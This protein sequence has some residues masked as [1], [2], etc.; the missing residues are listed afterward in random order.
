MRGLLQPG[1]LLLLLPSASQRPSRMRSTCHCNRRQLSCPASCLS[2]LALCLKEVLDLKRS[3]AAWDRQGG[4]GGRQEQK[5]T[6]WGA[7][8]GWD[9]LHARHATLLQ[10]ITT[11]CKQY[12]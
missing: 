2:G 11:Q 12:N 4:A 8:G 5:V 1:V 7:Q 3:H 9:V 10:R 6:G